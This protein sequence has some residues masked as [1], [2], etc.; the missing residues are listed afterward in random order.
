[1]TKKIGVMVLC[2]ALALGMSA[3]GKALPTA[4][5]EEGH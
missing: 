4:D 1:M 3:C 2:V 5:R